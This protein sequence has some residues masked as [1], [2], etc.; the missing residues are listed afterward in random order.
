MKKPQY[1]GYGRK[2][3]KC[4]V[5]GKETGNP[6]FCTW[7]WTKGVNTPLDKEALGKL[8][9]EQLKEILS[10]QLDILADKI[11]DENE[12]LREYIERTSGSGAIGETPRT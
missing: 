12:E 5:C 4:P 11:L 6:K 1:I 10:V 2:V 8:S 3:I 9:D 7:C